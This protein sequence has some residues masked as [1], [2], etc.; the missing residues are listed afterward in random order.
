MPFCEG[1]KS[2]AHETAPGATP[3][4]DRASARAVSFMDGVPVGRERRKTKTC[5]SLA[6]GSYYAKVMSEFF[7]LA[8]EPSNGSSYEAGR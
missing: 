5:L 3:S 8:F 1:I 4:P 2:S 6:I 7:C